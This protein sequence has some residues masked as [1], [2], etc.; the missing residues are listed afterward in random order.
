MKDYKTAKSFEMYEVDAMLRGWA[1]DV[2]GRDIDVACVPVDDCLAV[3]FKRIMPEDVEKINAIK[4]LLDS[5]DEIDMAVVER[6]ASKN[7]ELTMLPVVS[8][9]LLDFVLHRE[10]CDSDK[11]MLL[12]SNEEGNQSVLVLSE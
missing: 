3:K 5:C 12:V 9:A 1:R 7:S 6:R 8:A 11:D 10:G 2:F 4:L